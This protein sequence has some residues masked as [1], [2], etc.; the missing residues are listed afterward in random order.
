[1]RFWERDRKLRRLEAELRAARHEAPRD[2]I[3]TLLAGEREPRWLRPR[4]RIGVAVALAALALAAMAS[5]GG[6]GVI[7]HG[8]K[9]AV[10]VIKRTTHK[11]APRHVLASPAGNQ[12][13]PHCNG[14]NEPACQVTIYDASVR[15]GNSGLTAI[16]FTVA[17]SAYPDSP[18]H[19]HW[20]TEDR[21]ASSVGAC[22]ST[23][24]VPD[25]VPGSGDLLFPPGTTSQTITVYVC[26]DIVP[27]PNETFV[28]YITSTDAEVVRSPAT[29]T[30]LNDDR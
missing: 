27:E 21:T 10:H 4:L 12:Y 30:I 8:T 17:L 24:A 9:A 16:T 28:V 29:G 18:V 20:Y 13:Q 25:Y 1:M 14:P 7:K 3:R 26:G 22:N 19:V 11:S 2:F 23:S 5:A 6:M 15:E